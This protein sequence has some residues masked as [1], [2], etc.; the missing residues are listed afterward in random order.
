MA[1]K[2]KVRNRK[3]PVTSSVQASAPAA[4]PRLN[5]A[6]PD[7]RQLPAG[8]ATPELDSAVADNITRMLV[9]RGAEQ[10]MMNLYREQQAAEQAALEQEA[11]QQLVT[12]AAGAQA[13]GV[14]LN[15]YRSL[16]DAQKN[17][18]QGD[19]LKQAEEA[20]RAEAIRQQ[21]T[22]PQEQMALEDG[23]VPLAASTEMVNAPVLDSQQAL[24]IVR[25]GA[26]K[27]IVDPLG[28]L[29]SLG[30]LGEAAQKLG[31]DLNTAEGRNLY[32]QLYGTAPV[33]PNTLATEAETLTGQRLGNEKN[34]REL[35]FV[36]PQALATL[37]STEA[38]TTG[39][40]IDNVYKPARYEA[41]IANTKAGTAKINAE[42]PGVQAR[43]EQDAVNLEK[44]LRVRQIMVQN[45]P[46]SEKVKLLTDV[47][48]DPK[49][50][51]G[52]LDTLSKKEGI[53]GKNA[54]G[55]KQM[56]E[57]YTAPKPATPAGAP[58]AAKPAPVD[59]MAGASAAQK[60]GNFTRKVG[61]GIVKSV[62]VV[63]ALAQAGIAQK[64]AIDALPGQVKALQGL[65]A[66]LGQ[67]MVQDQLKQGA[68]QLFGDFTKGLFG[69]PAPQPPA[70]PA[71]R[72][73]PQSTGLQMPTSPQEAGVLKQA[74]QQN[75]QAANQNVQTGQQVSNAYGAME[76]SALKLLEEQNKKEQARR[77]Q[78]AKLGM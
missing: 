2:R 48:D 14:D 7:L 65:G 59:P 20:R 69:Q 39:Q 70:A 43:S 5:I 27:A 1:K 62:P 56:Y 9:Q 35:P 40:R 57:E 54:A 19:L 13:L 51:I 3:A 22:R 55:F 50:V 18:I 58:A 52:I 44:S 41:G 77:A 12:D 47:S 64:K 71:V 16:T 42:I 61:A 26:D 72:T 10:R 15:T 67:P 74:A 6:A 76:L 32:Q 8:L 28:K 25:M 24:N 45:L 33:T 66:A 23:R 38:G 31:I 63:G 49:E 34:R 4:A 78:Y 11:Q 17:T 60:A 37:E 21:F 36:A 46:M 73:A 75:A 29:T 53:L 30:I 68:Q